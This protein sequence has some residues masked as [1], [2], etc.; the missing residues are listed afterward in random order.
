MTTL[1]PAWYS[2]KRHGIFSDLISLL[3]PPYTLWHLSYILIGVSMAPTIYLDRSVAVLFAFFLGLGIGAH[4]LD[5]TMG[6]PLQTRLS[7]KS[8][9]VIGFSALFA[10]I[11]IGLYYVYALSVL[12]LPFVLIES[13]FA[14]AYNLE[15]FQSKFH[16]DLVFALSWGSIPYLTGYF[17][18]ALSISLA[19]IVM[20]VGIGL[21]TFVQRTL[22][23]QAR[24]WRRKMEPV[25]SMK[26]SSGKEVNV[27]SSELISPAEKSLKALT[28]MIF[29]VAI[30]LVLARLH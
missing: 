2:N 18:N 21:L 27:S 29:L 7:K 26:L 11:A 4:A 16:S 1:K 19:T 9:Y 15:M 5:E 20:A 10:A 24:L 8:L 13:F 23:T 14:L 6:N 12:I 17:V 30:A 25:K 28:I 3:H 22:S